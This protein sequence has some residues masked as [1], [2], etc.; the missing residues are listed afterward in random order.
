MDEE[1]GAMRVRRRLRI[2]GAVQGVGFRV[3]C[4]RAAEQAG[5]AGWV[6][7][8]ADGTVEAA[9]EGP[10]D[11]VDDVVAWCRTGPRAGRIDHVEVAEEQP[12]GEAGFAVRG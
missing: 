8:A 2:E 4:A 11:A 1:V 6:R 12:T 10:P 7:N 5:V 9:L 3:G